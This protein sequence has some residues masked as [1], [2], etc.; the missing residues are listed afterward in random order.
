MRHLCSRSKTYL[1]TLNYYSW[2]ASAPSTPKQWSKV[3]KM[4]RSKR[5]LSTI[6]S[7]EIHSL[8][9][10][11]IF[12]LCFQMS[13]LSTKKKTI[14]SIEALLHKSKNCIKT[15]QDFWVLMKDTTWSSV[16]HKKTF[17]YGW[18]FSST[19]IESM[20]LKSPWICLRLSEFS[21]AECP[22][23]ITFQTINK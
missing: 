20:P 6:F 9:W 18:M 12:H 4:S 10:K 8:I 17:R 5:V 16:T 11:T 21:T 14:K 22:Y 7:T 15:L 3:I 2:E 13:T 23:S 1:K 19:S